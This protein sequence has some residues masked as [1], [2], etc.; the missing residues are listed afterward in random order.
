MRL[1]KTIDIIMLRYVCMY[2]CVY[3][4]FHDNNNVNVM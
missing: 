2:I 3:N 1:E 4:V